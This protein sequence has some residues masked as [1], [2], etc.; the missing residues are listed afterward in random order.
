MA[1]STAG[2]DEGGTAKSARWLQKPDGDA[3]LLLIAPHGGHAGPATRA[4]LN[5]KVNDLHT[6]DITRELALRLDAGAIIN[7]GMDRNR[8][9]LNRLS[10]VM[11][12]APWLLELIAARLERIVARSG[13]AVVLLIH[14][15]NVIEPRVDLGVGIKSAGATLLPACDAHVS[16]S[17]GFINGPLLD[18]AESLRRGGIKSTFGLRYPGAGANNLLQAFTQRHAS[19]PVDTL[20]RMA[21]LN[22]RGALEAV[23]LELSVALRMPG[24]FRTETIAAIAEAFARCD[25]PPA[26]ARSSRVERAPRIEIIRTAEAPSRAPRRAAEQPPTGPRRVG[27]EFYD[28]SAQVGVMASFDLGAG[29]AGARVMAIAGRERIALFTAEGRVECTPRS[30]ALGPLTLRFEGGRLIFDFSGPAV[31]VEDGT[32][33][34]SVERALAKAALHEAT[35]L[36][37]EFEPWPATGGSSQPCAETPIELITHPQ[38][39]AEGIFGSVTG[40]FAIAGAEHRLEAVARL[41]GSFVGIGNGAFNARRMIWAGF[42]GAAAPHAVE[43]QVLI[44][45]DGAQGASARILDR[46]RWTSSPLGRLQLTPAAPGRPPHRIGAIL[47]PA[48]DG[49]ELTL[50]GEV[51]SFVMLSRPGPAQSRIITSLGFASFRIGGHFGDLRGAG[52]FERSHRGAPAPRPTVGNAETDNDDG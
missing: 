23:Q 16:A 13:R 19:S 4:L 47:G 11:S 21:A 44:D 37:A 28:S 17:D 43:A 3:P 7:A 9:D 42:P 22:A 26:A 46:G 8:L 29:A 2:S 25:R 12:E 36:H 41:G 32:A 39:A 18:F 51:R 40:H 38:R 1:R 34:L 49:L 50:A 52:M 24:R 27:L 15:W 10:Q 30:L 6:A 45:A 20:R 33:Y 5:P 48:G 35:E 31:V 14:G